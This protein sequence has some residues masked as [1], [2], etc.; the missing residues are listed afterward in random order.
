MQQHSILFKIKESTAQ[1]KYGVL[2]IFFKAWVDS[3]CNNEV[4]YSIE[5]DVSQS[6]D[7]RHGE[8]FR[9]DFNRHEDATALKLIGIPD[10]FQEYIEF[11]N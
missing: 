9:V 1:E 7:H 8:I 10:E 5:Y 6:P 3:T 4:Q 11:I 2:E